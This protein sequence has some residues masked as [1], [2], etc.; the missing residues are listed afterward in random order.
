MS[1]EGWQLSRKA[2]ACYKG[3]STY[4][5]CS[6]RAALGEASCL[7][8]CS[9]SQD[10]TSESVIPVKPDQQVKRA[11]Y[12]RRYYES[13]KDGILTRKRHRYDN[14]Q[15]YREKVKEDSMRRRRVRGTNGAV[16]VTVL[17]AELDAWRVRE[18]AKRVERSVSTI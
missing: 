15:E 12:N 3:C 18:R 4:R 8:P 13:H 16:R 17:G 2:N 1:L 5:R 6:F 7:V 10:M 14:D 9:W 11:E